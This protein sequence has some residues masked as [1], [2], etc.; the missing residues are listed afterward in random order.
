MQVVSK[1]AART[2]DLVC[3]GL[4]E[5]EVFLRDAREQGV[6]M[7]DVI[8]PPKPLDAYAA[9]VKAEPGFDF[10]F[11]VTAVQVF[12][13]GSGAGVVFQ[14]AEWPKSKELELERKLR[15]DPQAPAG[16]ESETMGAS[17]AFRLQQL[18]VTQRALLAMRADRNERRLLVR[19]NSAQVLLSLLSNPR[20]E[21][22]DVI[23]V[24][25][26]THA[27]SGILK[28]V[29]EDRRWGSNLEVKTAIVRNPK[30]PTPI[31]ARLMDTLRTEDLR[32]LSKMGAVREDVRRAALAAYLKRTGQRR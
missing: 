3:D 6:F 18:D 20:I 31:S 2:L 13:K 23:Q 21:A 9:M 26:S 19:D 25:K 1:P 10:Q 8:T 29:A 24:V 15:P 12:P 4:A 28:R 17:P 11:D 16:D 14:L 7:V 27:T 22:D 5:V 30:T 32:Q